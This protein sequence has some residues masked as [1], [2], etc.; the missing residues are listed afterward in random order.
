[1]SGRPLLLVYACLRTKLANTMPNVVLFFCRWPA[2]SCKGSR[3]ATGGQRTA[4]RPDTF[5]CPQVKL[6]ACVTSLHLHV[7]VRLSGG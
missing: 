7:Q 6:H 4:H 2:G 1:M 3:A 5:D